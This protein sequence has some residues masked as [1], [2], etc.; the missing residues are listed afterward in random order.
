MPEIGNS[1]RARIVVT[2]DPY[3]VER[4][5]SVTLVIKSLEYVPDYFSTFTGC[6][7]GPEIF[8]ALHLRLAS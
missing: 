5:T 8:L 2:E 7:A 4:D 6:F 3:Y 1:D